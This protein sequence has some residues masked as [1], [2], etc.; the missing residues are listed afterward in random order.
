V[1]RE[2]MINQSIKT[3]KFIKEYRKYKGSK[4]ELVQKRALLYIKELLKTEGGILTKFLQY[5]GTD[6]NELEEI[7][8][9]SQQVLEGIPLEEV[10]EVLKDNLGEKSDHFKEISEHAIAASVGQVHFAKLNNEKVAIKIQYPEVKKTFIEQLKIFKILPSAMK[11]SPMK[12]WG[13]DIQAYQVELQQLIEQECDYR[14]E[15]KQL[16]SWGGFLESLPHCNVPKVYDEYSNEFILTQTMIDGELIDDIRESWSKD[17]KKIIAKTLV[18]AYFHLF[19]NHQVIQGDSNHGNFLF[20]KDPHMVYFIDLGQTVNFSKDFVNAFFYVFDHKLR[21]EAFCSYSFLVAIGFDQEKLKPLVPK[22]DLVV[23]IL[24]GPLVADYAIDLNEW[25]YK[26]ELDL[27]LGEDKWWFRSAGGTEFFLFMKS[28]MGIK[29]LICKLGVNVFFK[30]IVQNELSR[31]NN[32]WDNI[33]IVSTHDFTKKNHSNN[34]EILVLENGS[35]KVKMKLPFM[36]IFEM[37]TYFE[38]DTLDKIKQNNIS[39]EKVVRDALADGGK[40]K[41]IFHLEYGTKIISISLQK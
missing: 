19:L 36:A 6:A 21:D 31:Q 2:A 7:Q 26:E 11:L 32:N 34:I 25:N 39:I 4:D 9:L 20:R 37:D 10:L 33:A 41:E 30:K 14:L 16:K 38:K 12:K 15:A 18:E 27:L 35:E 28:F 8:D 22:L 17:D 3:F 29:N 13:I 5:K 24:F 23:E 1:K 40:P